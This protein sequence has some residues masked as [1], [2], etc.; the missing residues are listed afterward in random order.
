MVVVIL[1]LLRNFKFQNDLK[2]KS[3]KIKWEK[4]YL[5]S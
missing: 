3:D 2:K 4:K 1:K 5:L